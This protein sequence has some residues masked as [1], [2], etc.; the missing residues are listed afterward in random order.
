[1]DLSFHVLVP[2]LTAWFN[3]LLLIERTSCVFETTRGLPLTGHLVVMASVV[4]LCDPLWVS[5]PGI[6][7]RAAL[8]FELSRLWLQLIISPQLQEHHGGRK[9]FCLVDICLICDVFFYLLEQEWVCS[10]GNSILW[11]SAQ[12]WRVRWNFIYR[13]CRRQ[14]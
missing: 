6:Y 2:G 14:W 8:F 5:P 11:G 1:M 10:R 13:S 4:V 12:S 3:L 9:R 7:R